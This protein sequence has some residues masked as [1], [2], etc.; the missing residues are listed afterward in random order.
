MK[1]NEQGG[2]RRMDFDIAVASEMSD[3]IAEQHEKAKAEGSAR[4]RRGGAQAAVTRRN[5]RREQEGRTMT[6]GEL[7]KLLQ[8]TFGNKKTGGE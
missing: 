2:W 8:D 6:G 1:Y 7:G 4:A 5:K 3:R